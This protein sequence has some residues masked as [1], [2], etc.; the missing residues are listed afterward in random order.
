MKFAMKRSEIIRHGSR[1]HFRLKR[2]RLKSSVKN[3]WWNSRKALW[4][5]RKA[6]ISLNRWNFDEKITEMKQRWLDYRKL[7]KSLSIKGIGL[8]VG[9]RKESDQDAIKIVVNVLPSKLE[10]EPKLRDQEI[11]KLNKTEKGHPWSGV[12]WS[13]Q[14]LEFTSNWGGIMMTLFFDPFQISSPCD[15]FYQTRNL[16]LR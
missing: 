7:R 14:P 12:G 1:Q 8:R 3:G 4:E 5:V 15:F 9:N 10:A 2:L 13:S 6:E 11:T 16:C